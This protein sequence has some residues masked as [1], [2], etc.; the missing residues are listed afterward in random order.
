MNVPM[1][2]YNE[3]TGIERDLQRHHHKADDDEENHVA[4]SPSTEHK[5]IGREA[6]YGG[7]QDRGGHTDLEGGP[8]R[9]EHA[10]RRQSRWDPSPYLRG[11]PPVKSSL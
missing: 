9:I 10:S 3:A 11:G 6:R 5:G 1:S 4:S 8:E 2:L 7:D